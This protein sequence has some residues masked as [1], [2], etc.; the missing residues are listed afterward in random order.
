[1]NDLKVFHSIQEF[2]KFRAGISPEVSVGF[3]P[4]MGALHAGHA[5]LIQQSALE[6][7]LT[8]LSIFVNPTQFNNPDDLKKYPRTWESDLSTAKK[9]GA[10]LILAPNY[11]EIYADSYRF[12]ISEKEFSKK[13]CGAHR[14]GH[15]EGVLTVVM[16]LL[17]IVAANKAYFGEK[18]YQQFKLIQELSAAF[19]LDTEI[20]PCPTRRE[21]DGLAMSSRNVRLSDEGRK[22]APLIY[23]TLTEAKDFQIAKTLLAQ[24]RIELEYLEEHYGR[25]FIAA[26]IDGVRLI[27]NVQI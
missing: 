17:Q 18:D 14:P 9:A 24:N 11:E 20:I 22:N 5:S 13:L 26:N 12:Q 15:F 6:N 1:M 3:V 8:V 23:K 21:A 2:R 7:D 4:T 10:N 27:D 25:R 19:F 16:K